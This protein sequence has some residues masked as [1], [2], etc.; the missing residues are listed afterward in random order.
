MAELS[1][2]A[3]RLRQAR[4]RAHLSQRELGVRAGIDPFAAS[5]RINQYERSKHTPDVGTA[6]RLA[7]VLGVPPPFLYAQDNALAAWI[8]AFDQI[9]PAERR[10][11]M[12]HLAGQRG[13]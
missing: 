7:R 11:I 4:L 9:R 13:A 6:A 3:R 2:V 1:V 5:A 10:S 8:L 12:R